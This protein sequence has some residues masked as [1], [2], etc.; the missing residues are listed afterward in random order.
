LQLYIA[1]CRVGV[2]DAPKLTA[3]T[4]KVV[5]AMADQPSRTFYGL[6]LMRETGLK[7]GSLYPILA[8]LRDH[9]LVVGTQE[10]GDPAELGRPLRTHFRLTGRGIDWVR[11]VEHRWTPPPFR[12]AWGNP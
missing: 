12:A 2:V 4:L 7:S 6:E 10:E 9:G 1:L 8:R 5:Q 3:A 11:E